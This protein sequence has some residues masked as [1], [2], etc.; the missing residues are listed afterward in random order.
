MVGEPEAGETMG[1]EEQDYNMG[2][3]EENITKKIH[4]STLQVRHIYNVTPPTVERVFGRRVHGG[5]RAFMLK[6]D[7]IEPENTIAKCLGGLK[8][9]INNLVQLQ[10]Y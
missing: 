5:V 1:R 4:T 10:L 8:Q 7:L 6:C 9:T 2:E 3:D